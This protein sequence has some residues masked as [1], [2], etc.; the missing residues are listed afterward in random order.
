MS[1]RNKFFLFIAI[2]GLTL[3]FVAPVSAQGLVPCGTKANPN[4][5]NVCDLL[6]L[7]QNIE[8]FV[9]GRL[10]PV[11]GGLMFVV[12]GVLFLIAGADPSKAAQ[13]K[14]LMTNTAI[15][16]AIIFASYM[17]TN[18]ILA[19]LA[20][21]NNVGTWY[22][23]KCTTTITPETEG[24][25]GSTNNGGTTGADPSGYSGDCSPADLAKYFGASPVIQNAP[26]LTQLVACIKNEVGT[27]I[28]SVFTYG[29]SHPLCNYT[30]GK[31]VPK[32]GITTCDHAT[33][34]CHYGGSSG[35]QGAL[36]VDF[37]NE[38]VGDAIIAA[39]KK[40]GAKSARC[41]NNNSQTVACT[42][43]DANHVHV[44]SISCDR[45]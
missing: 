3:V 17:L 19:S 4:P 28:G 45:N 35:T 5:C 36:A 7:G 24:G 22:T 1:L 23:I 41:E 43:S 34:S 37:G 15:G 21:K 18:S 38:K 40:C 44:N 10:L 6:V 29:N 42:S 16:I 12:G 2:I 33:N 11:V 26:E 14:S 27:D 20:G 39:A 25:D 9:L 32:C 13:G 30:H 8:K 31:K